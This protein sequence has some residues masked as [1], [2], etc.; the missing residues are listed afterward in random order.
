MSTGSRIERK[1]YHKPKK[2]KRQSKS[3]RPRRWIKNTI[4]TM[5]LLFFLVIISGAALFGYYASNS[6][7]ITE[8]DLIGQVS[9]KI[10]DRDGELIKELG[11][12][13]RDLMAPE[14]IPTVLEDAVL[15]I[16]DARFYQHNG[17]DPIRIVGS[18]VANLRAG[19]ILQGGSTITQ[20]LVK[21]S[22]FSTD[23]QDQTLERKA[24]EAWLALQIEQDLTKDEILTLYLNKMF[25]SNNTYGA[26]T[27]ADHFFGKNITDIN[28]AEAALLAGIPQ[29]PSDYDP[30]SNPEDAKERR[31]LVLS[32]MLDRD[33]ITEQAYNEAVNTSIESM[34]QPL[35][36]GTV[37]DIDFVMDSYLDVVA[38]EVQENF[39]L[40][41][42]TDGVEVY[43]NVDLD[44]QEHLYDT[45]NN[46]PSI[47]FTD[48]NMQTASSIV[49]VS[50]GQ[51]VAVIG[52]RQQDAIMGLNRANTLN[53]SVAS[54]M[55]PLSAYGPAFEYL[56]F[57]TGT[58]VVD[59]PFEYSNGDEIY[60]YD[61]EYEGDQTIR[62]AL[63]GS[64]NI[65]ALKVLQKVGLDN[66][67][68]FLQKMDIQILNNNEREL[69][70]ANAI[71]GEMTPIQLSGAYATIANYGQY[72]KPYSVS[73]VVTTAGSEFETEV[74][75]REAMKPS[76]AYMLVDVLKDVPGN[77][78]SL[79]DIEGLH[80]AG[81]TGTTNYTEDQ[82]QQLGIDSS[83]YAAPDG[84]YAGMTPQYAI[85]SWVGYDDPYQ[86]G[87][88]LTL[89]DTAIPQAIYSEM[90]TYLMQ[91]VPITDWQKPDSVVEV[92]IEKYTDPVKLP[93]PYTPTNM[94]SQELFVEGTQPSDQSEEFG[95]FVEAPT[96]F[97][98][99]YD[100]ANQQI[101]ANWSGNLPENATYV[102]TLDGQM[103]YQG[104]DTAFAIAAP[105]IGSY[106]LRLSIVSGNS[107]SDTLV[108]ELTLSQQTPTEETS[109]SEETSA[110]STDESTE[111]E[112]E[113]VENG[114]TPTDPTNPDNGTET[115]PTD[116]NQ[117]T[118]PP[119]GD[120][121][122]QPPANAG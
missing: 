45:V 53:R 113:P 122:Q 112:S 3:K 84:W 96:S 42:Y 86:P 60:N 24:Q 111:D 9:S 40:N 89:S 35:D 20:Q 2:Q 103:I 74:V 66:S 41:I 12:Q 4:I 109:E 21:L 121:G 69:V 47:G 6:P 13:N 114:E 39:N 50:T 17:V 28:L 106:V 36:A 46:N 11:G 72:T 115:P 71:G 117:P 49:D 98:A 1:K 32:V 43:T 87:N 56:N 61:F 23:F 18:L 55:K 25:Y 91:D 116:P 75:S 88:Y 108:I 105:Q 19:E 110:E 37:Q 102:L 48:D 79:S 82:L 59:E 5:I 90:M 57:S 27:A 95:Q 81:K 58:L 63:A 99:S 10:Y 107:S 30:Y 118:P 34:L 94:K 73:R 120:T 54:T 14:E 80:H 70:E 7:E 67:Y 77:F 119:G 83:T 78:A 16:E 85:A 8:A 97:N 29:A 92:E 68:A 93:G 22:V 51:L 104:T 64:R 33:M 31:D 15:A 52:G 76:T 26:K 101:V 100:Q 62:E 65:P 44:A 38:N